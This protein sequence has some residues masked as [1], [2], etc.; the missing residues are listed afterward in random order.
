MTSEVKQTLIET[1]QELVLGHQERRNL[2]SREKVLSF[3][4]VRK[5][6]F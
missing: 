1:L 6:R 5:L 3:M 2:F 4:S